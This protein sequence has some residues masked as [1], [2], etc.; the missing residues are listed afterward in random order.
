MGTLTT[1]RA[2][3]LTD[4]G[5]YG[6]GGGLYLV[7][8]PGGS[9]SWVLRVQQSGKRTD[10]GLGGY[11]AVTLATARRLAEDARVTVRRDGLQLS[12]PVAARRGRAAPRVKRMT[13]EAMA[14]NV[15]AVN[16]DAGLWCERNADQWI[17][18][19]ERYLFPAIGSRPIDDVSVA[20]LRDDILRPL[21]NEKSETAKRLRIIM[22]QVF[23]QA[24]EDGL[25]EA[26]PIDR[27]PAA[28]LRRPVTT[29]RRALP[30][31]DVP[32]AMQTLRRYRGAFEGRPWAATLDCTEF[33]IL[34]AVRPGEAR[35]ATWQEIDL[36]AR[37]WTIP[38]AKM[39]ARRDHVVPLSGAAL[40]CLRRARELGDGRGLLF[41]NPGN[42]RPI[43]SKTLED[44]LAK[45]GLDCVP[46][47]FRSSFRD[48]AAEVSG[49]SWETIE[50][51]LAHAVGSTVAQAYF[52]TDLVDQ[53][54]PLMEQWGD[55]I[56]PD[57][58]PF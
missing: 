49:A 57:R 10:R 56:L 21:A 39:K 42:G 12:K 40:A 27:I 3:R 6:D 37:T 13:F 14:R 22:R 54:R 18:R 50:L 11:P 17:H 20:V 26:N 9:R 7:V 53:R 23:Q 2:K 31:R 46:H 16:V 5:R 45:E 24:L 15:H 48:W 1:D 44:R 29:H 41:P 55:F 19:A 38:A 35:N 32:V 36:K 28:R 47:G 25:I 43:S 52:R 33:M 34:T 8:A 58:S 4:P 51:S 30:Y